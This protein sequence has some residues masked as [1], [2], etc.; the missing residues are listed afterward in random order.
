ME[1]PFTLEEQKISNSIVAA[2]NEFIK[3]EPTHPSDI[4]DWVNAIHTLQR[5]L[6]GRILRRD[7]PETFSTFKK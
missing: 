6:G 4:V 1:A 2:H 7:Y 5:I 3:L